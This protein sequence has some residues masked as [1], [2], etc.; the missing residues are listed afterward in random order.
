MQRLA[1]VVLVLVVAC[2]L[3]DPVRSGEH[4][5][6]LYRHL[7]DLGTVIRDRCGGGMAMWVV[8]M[9]PRRRASLLQ[10]AARCAPAYCNVERPF[11]SRITTPEPHLKPSSYTYNNTAATSGAVHYQQQ[12]QNQ[13]QQPHRRM[14]RGAAEA[15][16]AASQQDLGAVAA[17][18]GAVAQHKADA[19]GAVAGAVARQQAPVCALVRQVVSSAFESGPLPPAGASSGSGS[20][21]GA[22]QDQQQQQQQHGQK[23]PKKGKKQ[24]KQQAGGAA[25]A[26]PPP[27]EPAQQA[28]GGGSGGSSSGSS[29]DSGVTSGG[30]GGGVMSGYVRITNAGPAFLALDMVT[31]RVVSATREHLRAQADCSGGG[32]SGGGGDGGDS[33]SG[34]GATLAPFATAT[35]AWSAPLPAGAAPGDYSGVVATS[36]LALSGETCDSECFAA[37]DASGAAGGG[38]C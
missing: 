13:Q 22:Q 36:V 29:S 37:G 32:G 28:G 4:I 35:C 1:G 6:P 17:A 9:R 10:R 19:L 16:A 26:K 3:V 33:S 27:D 14:L 5:K 21:S 31:V 23:Q 25:A 20:G 7:F 15:R 30:G 12:Q 34:S 8:R 38:R 24:R 11:R 2:L 18:V